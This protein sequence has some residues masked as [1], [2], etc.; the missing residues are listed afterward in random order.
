M[1]HLLSTQDYSFFMLLLAGLMPYLFT[2]FA[3]L[4]NKHPYNNH[5]PRAFLEKT[6]G[7]QRRANNAQLNSFEAF[8]LFAVGVIV[9]HLKTGAAMEFYTLNLVSIGFVLTRLVYGFA[10]LADLASVRSVV[11]FIGLLLACSLYI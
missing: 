11:W 5:D 3:K 7:R 6:E 1:S 4:G 8:P 2:L 10:Y 9:A